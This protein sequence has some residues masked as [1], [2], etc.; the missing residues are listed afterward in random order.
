MTSDWVRKTTGSSE[1]YGQYRSPGP[2]CSS[3][4]NTAIRITLL[5]SSILDAECLETIPWQVGQQLWNSIVASYV[6]IGRFCTIA[7]AE[8]I[9]GK[10]S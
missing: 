3:L 6:K 4:K 10:A 9:I 2:G 7:Q 8:L 5:H 1:E